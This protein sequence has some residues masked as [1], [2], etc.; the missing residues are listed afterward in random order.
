VATPFAKGPRAGQ[1]VQARHLSFTT[2]RRT[3]IG[4]VRAGTATACL[5]APTRAAAHHGA[6]GRD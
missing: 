5:P 3:L 6:L 4:T 2:A 1:A